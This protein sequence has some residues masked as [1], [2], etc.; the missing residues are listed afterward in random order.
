MQFPLFFRLLIGQ[1]ALA[2]RGYIAASWFSVHLTLPDRLHMR[3]DVD[4]IILQYH[5]CVQHFVF[6][7]EAYLFF[8]FFKK[9]PHTCTQGLGAYLKAV[10]AVLNHD[11]R[12]RYRSHAT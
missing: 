4:K 12:A 2:L 3:L 7:P 1:R 9:H 10:D 6:K 11:L 8:V 5:Q